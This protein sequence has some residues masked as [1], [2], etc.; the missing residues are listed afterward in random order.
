MKK[1]NKR[2]KRKK[3]RDAWVAQSVNH[4]TLVRVMISRFYDLIPVSDSVLT[5]KSMEP[6]LDSVSPCLSPSPMLKI[7]LY[8]SLKI[9][10]IKKNILIKK[11]KKKTGKGTR[12]AQVTRLGDQNLV[13][14]QICECEPCVGLSTDRMEPLKSLYAPL[15]SSTPTRTLTLVLKNK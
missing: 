7:C 13:S 9:N 5:L 2:K 8:L 1:R 14:T 12:I 3:K 10:N 11:K 6:A 4:P 15:P